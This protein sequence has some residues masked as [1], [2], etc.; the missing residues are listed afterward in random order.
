MEAAFALTVNTMVLLLMMASILHCTH[1]LKK[2]V[3]LHVMVCVSLHAPNH[4]IFRLKEG[5]VLNDGTTYGSAVV[6]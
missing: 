3:N 4:T 2:H 5:F 6:I 1:D